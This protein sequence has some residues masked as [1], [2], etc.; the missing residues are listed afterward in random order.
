MQR[1]F[2][3]LVGCLKKIGHETMGIQ[4][5][6]AP[7]ELLEN[8]IKFALVIFLE[9][10]PRNMLELA[11]VKWAFL[12]PEWCKPDV[13]KTVDRHVDK[14]F[15]KTWEA[16]RIFEPMFPGRVVYTG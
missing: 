5:D 6:A 4:F 1:D 12:N 14:I 11:P 9:V 13:V 8:N 15:T 10:V 3:L 16:H 2:E 7:P